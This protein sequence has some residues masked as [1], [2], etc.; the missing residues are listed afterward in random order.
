MQGPWQIL[1]SQECPLWFNGM[2]A[3]KKCCLTV[4]QRIGFVMPAFNS[5]VNALVYPFSC[6]VPCIYIWAGIFPA[7]LTKTTVGLGIVV[8]S[9]TMIFKYFPRTAVG[10]RIM[11]VNAKKKH[12]LTHPDR[13]SS[14]PPPP[15]TPSLPLKASMYLAN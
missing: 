9:L 6:I 10:V 15:Y 2:P 5:L 3:G 11:D 12:S 8:L 4:M 7:S 13:V 1:F 14:P